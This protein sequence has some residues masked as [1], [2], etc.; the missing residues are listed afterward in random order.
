MNKRITVVTMAA[1]LGFTAVAGAAE[2]KVIIGF[3]KDV[4]V[5]DEQKRQRVYRSGGHLKR[6]HKLINAVSARIPAEEIEAL[7]KDPAVAYVEPDVTVGLIEPITT[8]IPSPEY[9]GSWGVTRIGG[10]D[11]AAAGFTGAGIKI[12]IL[13]SG[14]DCSHPD[15]ADN[16]RPG[17]N[18]AYDNNDTFDDGYISHGTHIAGIIGARNNGTGV[19]GVAPAAELYPVK[20]LGG[21]VMGD[22]SDIL[23]GMEWSILNGMNVI[24]LSIGA[25]IDSP[26]F[27]DACDRAYQA[28]IVVVSASGNSGSSTIDFP[29]AYDS[30]IAVSATNPDDT[31]ATFSN[32]GDKIELAAPGLNINSTMRGGGYGTMKGTSQATA[33]VTG[34]AAVL[35][36][37]KMSDTNGNGRTADEIR[38]LLTAS[39]TD[40]GVAGKDQYFGYG[41]VNLTKALTPP[42]ATPVTLKYTLAN[43]IPLKLHL[44]PGKY[45]VEIIDREMPLQIMINDISGTRR[46]ASLTCRKGTSADSTLLV[47][48]GE[49]GTLIF[50]PMGKNGST[51]LIQITQTQT[52]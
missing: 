26:S 13:D 39:A 36:S 16:C 23:A 12:A 44:K 11:A 42:P 49:K 45:K 47:T 7:K 41:L 29:A 28:G 20:V 2:K 27:K 43:K 22:L 35:F 38:A 4:I 1:L 15:L 30:V 34:A 50:L 33:H 8:L 31:I 9:D 5:S 40:L 46:I 32:Y 17:Y 6:S 21:S 24:N 25:P 3:K 48:I 10:A 37:K 18:F 19:V 52:Q 14:I 51:A